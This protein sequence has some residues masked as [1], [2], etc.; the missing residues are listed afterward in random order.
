MCN[1]GG[2]FR[3][4]KGGGGMRARG[5]VAKGSTE[6][7]DGGVRQILYYTLLLTEVGKRKLEIGIALMQ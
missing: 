7:G 4:K 6:E 1:G 3:H 2:V 5:G